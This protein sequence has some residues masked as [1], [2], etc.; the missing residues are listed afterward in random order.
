VSLRLRFIAMAGVVACVLVTPTLSMADRDDGYGDDDIYVGENIDNTIQRCDIH[1]GSCRKFVDPK[2]SN[3]SGPRGMIF[4]GDK[5]LVVNQ[6]VGSPN[7]G[8]VL[9]FDARNGSYLA[10]ALVSG[11]RKDAPYAPRGMVRGPGHI[12]YVAEFGTEGDTCANGRIARYDALTGAAITPDL[13]YAGFTSRRQGSDTNPDFHPR[14]IV[15]GPD[16]YLYVTA[17]ACPYQGTQPYDPE[18]GYVIR[19]DPRTGKYAGTVAQTD[20]GASLLHRPEGIL[21]DRA[22]NLWVTS[23][24]KDG[25]DLNQVDVLLRINPKTGQQT[26]A[27]ALGAA[28]SRS[29]PKYRTTAQVIVMGPGGDI[30][31]PITRG[32][33]NLTAPPYPITPKEGGL[34][35]CNPDNGRCSVVVRNGSELTFPW[36]AVFRDSESSTLEND[37][38]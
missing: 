30:F 26:G 16:G 34:W 18:A 28:E 31:V 29:Y 8:E 17:F 14:G 2:S 6:N 36:Y 13:D 12:L 21:F 32:P 20:K 37:D 25:N 35:R 1:R 24:R 15:F 9:R 11:A 22:G 5:L 3:L 7:N 27:I 33:T 38:D 19:F 4:S 23:F 10:P